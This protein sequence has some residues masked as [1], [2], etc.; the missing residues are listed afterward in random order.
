MGPVNLKDYAEGTI[1]G[2]DI[3]L[4]NWWAGKDKDHRKKLNDRWDNAY[5]EDF[6]PREDLGM[7]GNSKSNEFRQQPLERRV[8]QTPI[9]NKKSD[10]GFSKGDFDNF[11]SKRREENQK[12]FQAQSQIQPIDGQ[13]IQSEPMQAE[14][15][16]AVN[17]MTNE[18][19][20]GGMLNH[21]KGG[22]T[23]EQNPMGG[24]DQGMGS[25]GKRNTVE[26]D[27]TS[28][29]FPEGKFIFSNRVK[30]YK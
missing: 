24:I 1:K 4:D 9:Y 15:S 3:Y 11:L 12:K 21:F 29:D 6:T 27:E 16:S 30:I 28:F 7:S 2:K 17:T 20:D 19:A 10:K 8:D 5:D 22:G 18:N 23:H 14:T 26:E 25:N 13:P